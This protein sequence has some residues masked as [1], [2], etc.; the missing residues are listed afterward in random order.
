MDA[1]S[2]DRHLTYVIGDC[3]SE[4]R[5]AV[6]MECPHKKSCELF[7]IFR[8][9]AAL[10]VWQIRYCD[11]DYSIC[12]RFKAACSARIIPINMLPNGKLLAIDKKDKP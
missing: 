1:I 9:K 2:I 3:W 7:P 8:L 12:E 5:D 4:R 11:G 6:V 10:K